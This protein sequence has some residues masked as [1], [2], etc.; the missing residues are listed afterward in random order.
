MEPAMKIIKLLI[1]FA[2][3]ST[4]C[5]CATYRA[6]LANKNGETV[7]CNVSGTFGPITS[8]YAK[9]EIETCV[10]NADRNGYTKWV[11]QSNN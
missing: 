8:Y 1:C 11:S 4:L 9:Q 7:E 3:I 5:S 10:K 6:T 2:M